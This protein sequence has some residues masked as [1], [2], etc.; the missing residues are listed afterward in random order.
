MPKVDI[1]LLLPRGPNS[2]PL[3]RLLFHLPYGT[4]STL[5]SNSGAVRDVKPN[6]TV[7]STD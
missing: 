6:G 1:Q 3:Q 5:N 4:G 2:V 7:A